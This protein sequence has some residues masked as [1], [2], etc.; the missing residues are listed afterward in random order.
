MLYSR[1]FESQTVNLEV[2]YI[3]VF[4]NSLAWNTMKNITANNK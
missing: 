3:S 1:T 4:E 2:L